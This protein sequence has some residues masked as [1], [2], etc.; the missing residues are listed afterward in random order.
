MTKNRYD[1]EK[2]RNFYYLLAYAFEEDNIHFEEKDVFGTEKFNNIYDLFSIVL[3]IRMSRIIKE[4]LYNE[5][6]NNT[7]KTQF[8]KG[9]VDI[10][11]TMRYNILK[12][13]SKVICK[14]DD[15][16]TNN[17]LNRIVKTTIFNLLKM[18]IIDTNKIR[19][20]QLYYNLDNIE[21]IKD[22]KKIQWNN[23]RFNRLNSRYEV[24]IKICEYIL[25]KLIINKEAE[26]ETFESFND[27]QVYH[28][29]FEKFIRNYL[30]LYYTKYR[31]KKLNNIKIKSEKMQWNIDEDKK[32]INKK[33]VPTM[34]TDITIE[35]NNKVKI[36]DAKFY[37]NILSAR[38]FNG[39]EKEKINSNNW[40][41]IYSYISNKKYEL[42]KNNKKQNVNKN[43]SVSGMLLYAQTNEEKF[44][45]FEV[46][47]Y[48]MGN[49]MQV[50][51]IDFTKKFGDP[52]YPKENTIVWN[53]QIL[54]ENI[55]KELWE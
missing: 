22:W 46:D 45:D 9:R 26:S 40:Y 44:S 23:I 54:A 38:T 27:A 50:K 52:Y 17:L 28:E 33:Y 43:I 35:F 29:L 42:E 6:I 21:I 25:N 30:K 18:D 41:Q 8:I 7:E 47:V 4:G 10:V 48:V 19:L 32:S 11:D 20:M 24:V 49:R 55:L 15:Y 39:F 13:Q 12:T 5:Y 53:M 3:Y 36:I 16:S 2:V 51:T 31:S 37:S 1:E 34:H 14:Y